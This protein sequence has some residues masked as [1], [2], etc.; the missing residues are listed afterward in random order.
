M[1]TFGERCAVQGGDRLERANL[2]RLIGHFV[3]HVCLGVVGFIALAIPAILLSIAAHYLQ[4]IAVSAV[5]IQ[6]LLAIHYIL[7]VIDTIMFAAYMTVAIY[8]AAK[9][10]VQYARDL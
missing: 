8:D 4:Q 3:G 5:V 2:S 10:L 6:I 7:I 9:E 1:V